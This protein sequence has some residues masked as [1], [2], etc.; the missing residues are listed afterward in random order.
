[1][2]L[3]PGRLRFLLEY[4]FSRFLQA[5]LHLLL[6]WKAYDTY[7]GTIERNCGLQRVIWAA[8]FRHRE[9]FMRLVGQFGVLPPPGDR[10]LESRHWNQD[11]GMC[12]I[13]RELGV[14]SEF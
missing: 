6:T 11:N 2:L 7:P 4:A 12:Q 3:E 13:H 1:L 5:I 14:K 9:K 8:C 10:R